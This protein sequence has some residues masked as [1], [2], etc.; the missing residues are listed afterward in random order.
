MKSATQ[1]LRVTTVTLCSNPK[2]VEEDTKTP[3]AKWWEVLFLDQNPVQWVL[4]TLSKSRAIEPA[5]DLEQMISQLRTISASLA[6]PPRR[7][8]NHVGNY[9]FKNPPS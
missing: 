9:S 6:E 1:R 5:F 7:R 2:E 3:L 4:V 8:L